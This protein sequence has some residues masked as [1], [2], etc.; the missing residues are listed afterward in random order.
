MVKEL[1]RRVRF[2]HTVLA[3]LIVL[4]VSGGVGLQSSTLAISYG[5]AIVLIDDTGSDPG[6]LISLGLRS[7]LGEYVD[8]GVTSLIEMTPD[9]FAAWSIGAELG[10]SLLAPARFSDT[11]KTPSFIN[12]RVALGGWVRY[13]PVTPGTVTDWIYELDPCISLT[14]TPLV[15]GNAFYGSEES[16]METTILFDIREGSWSLINRLLVFSHYISQ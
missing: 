8:L 2:S 5:P 1:L 9:P 14:L 6:A 16:L 15:M 4:L 7:G 13:A 12:S 11:K 3:F 10:V